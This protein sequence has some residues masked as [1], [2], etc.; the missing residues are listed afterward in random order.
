M[1]NLN[2]LYNK[3]IIVQNITKENINNDNKNEI[4]IDLCFL[5]YYGKITMIFDIF[6]KIDINKSKNIV[7]ISFTE[8]KKRNC[9]QLA[10]FLNFPN[11]FL[12]LLTY[13]ADPNYIDENH[14]NTWHFI[15]YKGNWTILNILLNFISYKI[16]MKYLN[17][18]EKAKINFGFGKL[19]IAKGK[20]SKAI[21][22]TKKVL[23]NFNDLQKTLKNECNNMIE[24]FFNE[25]KKG[26]KS[27]DKEGQNPL[28]FA[29]MSKFSLCQKVLN[30]ILEFN[31]VTLKKENFEEFLKLFF[32]IQKLEVK[33]ERTNED[34]RRI[35]RLERELIILLGEDIIKDL[36][37]KF[38]TEKKIFFKDLINSQDSNGNSIL[39]ISSFFG[40]YRIVKK[41]LLFGGNKKLTND[42]G[43]LPIDLAKD[44]FVR[45]VL[46]NLNKAANESDQKNINELI[47]FGEDINEKISIFNQAPIHKIIESKKENKHEVLKNILIMG[48]DPNLKDSNGWTPL[49]YACNYGDFESVK[50]LLEFGAFIDNYSNNR[51]IPLHFAC[52]NNHYEIVEFL[53]ENGSNVNFKDENGCSPLHL[54]AKNGNTKCLEILLKFNGDLYDV[55]FRGWNILHYCAFHGHKKTVKFIVKYDADYDILKNAKNSNNKIPVEIVREPEIKK[56]F[57]SIFHAAKD[58]N[59]DLTKN[60]LL[61]DGENINQQTIFEQNTPLILATLNS[62]FLEVRLLLENSADSNVKNK[63]DMSAIDYAEKMYE[64]CYDI[65]MN[66]KDLDREKMDLRNVVKKIGDFKNINSLVCKNNWDVRVWKIFDFSEK[67]C[68]IFG[69]S[70]KENKRNDRNKSR[71]N[72]KKIIMKNKYEN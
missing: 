63:D 25:I 33:K 52:C 66:C 55:D 67:I 50:I 8:D 57:Y 22:I 43:N 37:K 10:S 61:E 12:Y 24:D 5:T 29:A 39:H 30:E 15:C 32:E 54:S 3:K 17:I 31:F 11:I 23:K 9:L 59:L 64:I 26:L 49:H 20:L 62:H 58:G 65:Y 68:K 71:K 4:K 18:I 13:D 47:N 45:K 53:C 46:T 36:D 28:H 56:Y 60:L 34:P 41:L 69:I 70:V 1:E 40:D 21:H 48:S 38:S 19:D 72:T 44:N 7:Q 16:K 35:F 51:K 6:N 2:E 27:K 42:Y 14:Q